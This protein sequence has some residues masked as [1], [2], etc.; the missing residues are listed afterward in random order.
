MINPDVDQSRGN[1]QHLR[2][3]EVVILRAVFAALA[4]FAAFALALAYGSCG[5]WCW[6]CYQ[7]KLR[8]IYILYIYIS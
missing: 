5:A 1:H 6:A 3:H 7:L 8:A 4:V 2:R